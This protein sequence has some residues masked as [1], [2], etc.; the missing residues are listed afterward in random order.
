MNERVEREACVVR[1]SRCRK[2]VYEKGK[3]SFLSERTVRMDGS[4]GRSD[5]GYAG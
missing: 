4:G 3:R 2:S 1:C 5:F